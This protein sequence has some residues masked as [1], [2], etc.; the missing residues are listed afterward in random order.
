MSNE[1]VTRGSTE[2]LDALLLQRFASSSRFS[3]LFI[4]GGGLLFQAFTMMIIRGVDGPRA[5]LDG[6]VARGVTW[7]V[8]GAALPTVL[9]ATRLMNAWPGEPWLLV[10]A[11][12]R[13][14]SPI[15]VARRT[16]IAAL[17]VV[18]RRAIAMVLP[19]VLL[20][21]LLS[22]PEPGM[23]T[24]RALTGALFVGLAG[25]S[26]LFLLLVGWVGARWLGGRGRLLIVA[27]L[28]LPGLFSGA[29]RKMRHLSPSGLY[30]AA[31]DAVQRI[32]SRD[33]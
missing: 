27:L 11:R 18:L 25:A 31:N 19:L 29:S 17:R 9:G 30:T 5:N 8:I 7:F 33:R 14:V 23:A 12:L 6:I 3:S 26:S 24:R 28:I 20:S 4:A 15:E 16:P 22:L 13:G 1:P 32:A 2:A 10:L 21:M